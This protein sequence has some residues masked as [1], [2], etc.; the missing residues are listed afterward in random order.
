MVPFHGRYA[1]PDDPET[2]K[3][4]HYLR[5][6]RVGGVMLHTRMTP[7]GI[8]R[9]EIKATASLIQKYQK[10]ARTPLF[11]A[12]DFERGTAM[13][14]EGGTSFSHAMAIAASGLPGAA[15]TVGRVT[16]QE[17]LEVGI[18]W[19][20]APVA[21]VNSNP[22]NP[23]VNIRSFGENAQDVAD[24]VGGFVWG[25]QF[26]GAL[27]TAKHFPGHGDSATDSHLDLPRITANRKR[28]NR[29]ELV[30]FRAA[31]SAGVGSIM[32]GHLAVPALEPDANLPATLSRRIL[33][34][35]LRKELGFRGLIV[36]DALDMAGIAARYSPGEAAVRAILAGVDVL[37]LSPSPDEAINGLREA[38]ASG[39]LSI[40]RVDESVARILRAKAGLGL[41]KNKRAKPPELKL[42][43]EKLDMKPAESAD[44]LADAGMTLLRDVPAQIP[45]NAAKPLRV[46]LVSI[47]ADPDLLPGESFERE[48][49]LRADS[50]NSL[51]VDAQFSPAAQAKIPKSDSYDVAVVALFVRVADRKGTIALPPEQ[52]ELVQRFLAQTKPVIV[53]CFGSPYVIERFPNAPTWLAA[54]STADVAQ[55]AAARALFGEIDIRGKLPVSIPGAKP[56]LTIGDGM[57]RDANRMRLLPVGKKKGLTFQRV[58]SLIR[59]SVTEGAFPGGTIAVGLG[60][61]LWLHAF[62]RQ[63]YEKKSPI[64][65]PDSI[66]DVAS[67]T[68]PVVTTTLIAMEIETGR[69]DLD[70]PIGLYLPGWEDGEQSEWRNRVTLRHLLTHTS[71]LPG[72]VFYYESAKTKRAVNERAISEKLISEPGAKVEYSDPGFMLLGEVLERVT[73]KPLQELAQERIF[74]PLGMFDTL[75]IPKR[76]IRKWIAPTGM[77]SPLRKRVL[78]GEVNDDNAFVMGG[79]AGHA[80]LFSTADDLAIFCR[81]MLNGGIY[82]HRRLLRRAT[83]EQFT[84]AQ[85]IS[86]NTRALGWVVRTEPSASGRYFSSRSFGHAGFTGTSLWCDPEKDLFVVLLTNRVH[87]TRDNMTIQEIRPAIHDAVVEALGLAKK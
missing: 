83:V 3:L 78:Q 4:L 64:I 80:G 70:A 50:V 54:F 20:F 45:L 68:K 21:D 16:A 35:L 24:A 75:W 34:D 52:I 12:A 11:V 65:M 14:L 23:I 10:M 1:P 71:G 13:R 79:V 81:M 8:E 74:A 19:I 55:C 46:L 32:T 53:V 22:A 82:A 2:K 72:K 38:V 30:P 47:D 59:Q 87:P 67:L 60:N 28:L 57:A 63:T 42:G 43:K 40:A 41:F 48:L 17:A 27:A 69:V 9:G 26:P 76:Q 56:P 49:R 44:F 25:V 7:N 33:T 37:L 18:N 77:D 39:R 6:L 36:T 84:S 15:P 61:E 62:G 5:D 58:V 51:H 85:P 66:Y 29:V 86:G 31:I 73:G